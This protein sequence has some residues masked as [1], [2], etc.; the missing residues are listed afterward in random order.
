MKLLSAV[1]IAVMLAGCANVV[2]P[3]FPGQ[4]FSSVEQCQRYAF[5]QGQDQFQC[6]KVMNEQAT[7]DAVATGLLAGL[8][9]FLGV[10]VGVSAAHG[11]R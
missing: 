8:V 3:A 6:G 2:H 10:L 1:L 9:V 4:T 7:N 5:Q 11:G